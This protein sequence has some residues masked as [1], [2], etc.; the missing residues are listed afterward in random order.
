ME[1]AL[2]ES[3]MKRLNTFSRLSALALSLVGATHVANGAQDREAVERSSRIEEARYI[4]I[5]GIEQ[6]V[7]LR[8]D[9]RDAPI[10]LL[11]HGGPGD[12]QSPLTSTYEPFE[13][14]YVL[15]QWDQRGA[16][17]TYSKNRG[18]DSDVTLERIAQDGIELS[19]HLLKH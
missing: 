6:W 14:S 19:E 4:S 10:L 12:S 8:G 2:M 18:P 15:V 13:R 3:A 5:G 17:K 9:R 16:G 7:T 11:L 1:S